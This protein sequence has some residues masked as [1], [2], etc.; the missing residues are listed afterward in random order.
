MKKLKYIF[1]V[2][3]TA[4]YSSLLSAQINNNASEIDCNV[5]PVKTVITKTPV[6]PVIP[7]VDPPTDTDGDG[8]PDI[9]EKE[10]DCPDKYNPDSDGDGRLDGEDPCPCNPDPNCEEEIRKIF[11]VH[12]FTPSGG[13]SAW[14]PVQDWTQTSYNN[15]QTFSFDYSQGQTEMGHAANLMRQEIEA[16]LPDLNNPNKN[17]FVVAHSLGGMVMRNI[18]DRFTSGVVPYDGVI[19]FGVGH[20]GV[21]A[22][23]TYAERKYVFR[24]TVN[25]TCDHLLKPILIESFGSMVTYLAGALNLFESEKICDKIDGS[26][27]NLME[28]LQDNGIGDDLTPASSQSWPS[29]STKHNVP[30]YGV[31]QDDNIDVTIFKDGEYHT[32]KVNGTLT[33]RFFGAIKLP[34]VLAGQFGADQ[35][36]DEGLKMFAEAI[37]HF[38]NKKESH[39]FKLRL[40]P[41]QSTVLN[42]ANYIAH[43]KAFKAYEKG[44]KWF[45]QINYL[46]KEIIGG[47]QNI[48]VYT[49]KCECLIS[50]SGPIGIP[51]IVTHPGDCNDLVGPVYEE[52]FKIYDIQM[53][54]HPSD[55]FVL[56]KT[57]ME[58][59]NPSTDPIKMTGSNHFQM[60]ND[61]QTKIVLENLY[62][63]NIDNG[64]FN[65]NK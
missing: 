35:S 42:Y 4:L 12:G 40:K 38:E 19:S 30:L 39:K 10:G 5:T 29:G 44:L 50:G 33:P 3:I 59:P 62:E 14:A 49:D 36:D 17:N 45:P 13:I 63:K 55:G 24:N 26:I 7:E 46:W 56:T 37:V 1:I 64:W 60:R 27:L 34:P 20:N 28:K 2:I 16:V 9:D 15:V 58:M 43:H 21:Y 23:E 8:L 22:S 57:A 65:I 6:N 53:E 18:E 25:F 47:I 54:S 11:F 41:L 32:K 31:E 52:C 51:E 61:S 48:Q